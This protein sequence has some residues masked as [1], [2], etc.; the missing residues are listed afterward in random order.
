MTSRSISWQ[1]KKRTSPQRSLRPPRKQLQ[2]CLRGLRALC[3]ESVPVRPFSARLDVSLSLRGVAC[4][5]ALLCWLGRPL[6]AQTPA[7]TA[8]EDYVQQFQ[9]SYRQVRSLRADF[10]QTYTAG[11]RTRVEAGRVALA[12]GGLM[13][14]DYQ[15]PTVKLFVSDG[16]QVLFYV[17]EAHQLTRTP[18]KSS[19]DFRV[20]F[21]LL[22]TRLDLHRVFAR[23]ELADKVLDHPPADHVLRAFPKKEFALDYT[24]VLIELDPQFDIRRLVINY[25]DHSRMDFSFD[26]IERNPP[27]P[28]SLFEFTPPPGTQIIDQH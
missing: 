1:P 8:A 3:G 6:R 9:S 28:R 21:E 23:E 25:S 22:L 4:L 5:V 19:E 16:K 7:P 12:R 11:G 14:W 18:V 13:R 20:P 26:H 27:L 10:T 15:R 17:P 2:A 24:D